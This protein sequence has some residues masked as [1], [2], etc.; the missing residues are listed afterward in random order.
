LSQK[1]IFNL[2]GL[3]HTIGSNGSAYRILVTYPPSVAKQVSLD[4]AHEH[5]L[6]CKDGCFGCVEVC[7]TE[8]CPLYLYRLGGDPARV[9]K[10]QDVGCVNRI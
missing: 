4:I 5:C 7:T 9:N 2:E 6:Q 10:R 3:V 8:I 1:D